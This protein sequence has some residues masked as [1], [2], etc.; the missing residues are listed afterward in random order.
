MTLVETVRQ[1]L[2]AN[3]QAKAL[4][5]APSNSAADIIA[6]RLKDLGPDTL[7]RF[8]APSR[9]KDQ[10]PGELMPYTHVRP[11]GHFTVPT[12]AKMM[13]FRVIVS[14]CVSG[15]V[16]SGI[17]MRRGHFSHIFVDEAGQATEPEVAIS[18]MTMADARTNIILSGDPKQ[19]G[20]ILRSRMAA[21]LG[22]EMSYIERLMQRETYDIQSGHGFTFVRFL[23]LPRLAYLWMHFQSCEAGQEFSVA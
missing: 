16:V 2:L 12:M 18:I 17:G 5:C 14:T 11:D 21:K 19:L 15:S 8:Y 4:V 3:P 1:I 22:L 9:F 10:V 7:F 6:L 20:P 23:G 13:R